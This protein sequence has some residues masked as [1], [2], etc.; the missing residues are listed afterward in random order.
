LALARQQVVVIR[1]LRAAVPALQRL[2]ALE[3]QASRR[4]LPEKDF[5]ADWVAVVVTSSVPGTVQS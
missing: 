4:E 1:S 5:A 2:D 3:Q